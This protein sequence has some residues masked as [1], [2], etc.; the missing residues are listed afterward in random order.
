VARVKS[1][2]K[3]IA[4]FSSGPDEED[5]HAYLVALDLQ[6]GE[7]LWTEHLSTSASM[8]MV[9]PAT[10]VDMD[11][12]GYDDLLY[13]SDLAGNVWKI[14]IENEPWEKSLVFQ[15]DQPI[16]AEPILTMDLEDNIYL[17]FGTGRYMYPEDIDNTDLQTFYSIIDDHSGST[18]S[19][20]DLVDQT[21]V[22]HPVTSDK[23]GWYVDLVT[24]PGERIVKPD[25]LV[26]G[27][28]YF[29]SFQPTSEV[30]SAGGRSWLYSVDYLDG[31]APDCDDGSEND[32][33]DGRMEELDEGFTSKP[34]ID[35]V[36]E[37]VI[38]QSS[39]TKINV[40]DTKT[41]IRHLIVRSWRPLYQ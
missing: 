14:D 30:C 11:F 29:T 31:S 1:L 9:T 22:I 32:T 37:K 33:T 5:G 13:L 2:D 15:T 20:S 27:V 35:I 18:V 41:A 39:D 21:S 40:L 12:D 25:A 4:F 24:A 17:Y 26:A 28:V 7:T 3:F 10:P 6:S 19:R 34:V 38:I 8:N 16:Q 23:R 36:N